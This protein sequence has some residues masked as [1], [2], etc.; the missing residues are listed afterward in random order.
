VTPSSFEQI[1][2]CWGIEGV[3]QFLTMYLETPVLAFP[4]GSVFKNLFARFDPT[5]KYN[6][7]IAQKQ[8]AETV[9]DLQSM[10]DYMFCECTRQGYAENPS[11]FWAQWSDYMN[12]QYLLYGEVRD[13]Y[14]EHLAS[15]EQV[16]SYRCSKLKMQ[17]SMEQ[18]QKAS[19]FLSSFEYSNGAYRILAP[20]KPDDLIEEGRQLSHC[21]GSYTDRVAALDTFIF[22]LRRT[23]DPDR[24]LV[25]VQVNTDGRLGQVRGR[26]NR[27][28]APEQMRFVEK[29]HEKFFKNAEVQVA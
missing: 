19:E 7:Y 20:R 17:A 29:W 3:R 12:Q 10:V 22:F 9:F 16:L 15:D 4:E 27:Q 8:V 2:A 14:S 24:S 25:T 21:V 18:F 5:Q 13:K 28:P 11:G 6:R 23:S 26:F 1:H